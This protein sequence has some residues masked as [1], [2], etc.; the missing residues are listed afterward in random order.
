MQ[1]KR[2]EENMDHWMEAFEPDSAGSDEASKL[3]YYT[4]EK[5]KVGAIK[6]NM[7]SLLAKADSVLKK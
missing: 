1:L 6:D 7:I 2:V 5:N 4:A 3:K